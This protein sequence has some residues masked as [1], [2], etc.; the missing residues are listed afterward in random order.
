MASVGAGE[1]GR[2]ARLDA[3]RL[4]RYGRELS[5]PFVATL[6]C[7]KNDCHLILTARIFGLAAQVARV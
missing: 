6:H 5:W 3:P 4:A 1:R 7:L 2:A